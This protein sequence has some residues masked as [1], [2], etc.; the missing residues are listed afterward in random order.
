MKALVT[1]DWHLDHVTDGYPR[2]DEVEKT[3]DY[4]VEVALKEGVDLY[5]F[6]GD[7]T[8]PDGWAVHRAQAKAIQVARAL[9]DK[10]IPSVWVAGNHDVV[11]DGHGTTTL[12]PLA[13]TGYGLVFEQPGLTT[14]K[15][16]LVMALPFTPRS[17]AYEPEKW[18]KLQ[19]T[20]LRAHKGPIIVVGHLNLAGITPGS[21]TTEMPRGREVTWPVEGLAKLAPKATLIAG[22]YHKS[23]EFKG[24]NVVGSLARLAHGEELNEPGMLLLEV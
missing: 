18:L 4:S 19:A 1:S 22:H 15:G 24:V 5:I 16:V 11:E 14:V 9:A 2:W 6:G 8:D 23:Q 10:G 7:L 12:T 13:A 20:K 21:E 17:H 3:V